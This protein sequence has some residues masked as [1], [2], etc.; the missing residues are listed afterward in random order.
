[1]FQMM[2]YQTNELS[3]NVVE[4]VIAEQSVFE[5]YRFSWFSPKKPIS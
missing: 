1:M 4:H 5:A 3:F 2:D